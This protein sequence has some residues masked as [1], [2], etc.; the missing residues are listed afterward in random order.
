M[1]QGVDFTVELCKDNQIESKGVLKD[2]ESRE[3][4]VSC[5]LSLDTGSSEPS[6]YSR[7]DPPPPQWIAGSCVEVSG[8]GNYHRGFF[9]M[10]STSMFEQHQCCQYLGSLGIVLHVQLH[11]VDGIT[12]RLALF[13]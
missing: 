2:W 3:S 7:G 8:F 5:D 9:K 6:Y 1:S 11:V 10:F 13:R 12:D 4:E